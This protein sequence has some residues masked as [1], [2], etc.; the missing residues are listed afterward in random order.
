MF[1]T[2]NFEDKQLND[3]ITNLNRTYQLKF[4]GVSNACKPNYCE[5]GETWETVLDS[6]VN[7][8]IKPKYS[9]L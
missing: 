2:S 8:L 7:N 1:E 4:S 3:M 9:V 5:R 6:I